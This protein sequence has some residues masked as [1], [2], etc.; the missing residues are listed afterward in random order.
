M[1]KFLFLFM[2][3][4]YQPKEGQNL[5]LEDGTNIWYDRMDGNQGSAPFVFVHGNAQNHT[6]AT[7][8]LAHL[9]ELGHPVVV[10]HLPGHGK[11]EA[12]N[13]GKY[14]MGRFSE[15]LGKV[16]A[17]SNIEKPILLAHSMGGM[18]AL[19]YATENP[20]KIR[21]L[22]LV[23]TADVDPVAVNKVVPLEKIV[24]EIV[25]GAYQA[26]K[27]G[28]SGKVFP[29]DKNPKLSEDEI[30]GIGLEHTIPQALDGNFQATTE[31]D[32]RDKIG[33]LKVP[34][35]II[36]GD[37]DPLMTAEMNQEMHRRLTDSRLVTVEGYG[38]NFL[39]QRPDLLVEKIKENYDFV[40]SKE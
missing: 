7:A 5:T 8:T 1:N 30:Q 10:Y 17:A 16:I 38:H 37:E 22:V 3:H 32:V 12:Y 18:I 28:L 26:F 15:T 40:T 4:I 29:Y 13:D 33:D 9:N 2:D 25:K 20:D 39:I 31:Y 6:T 36:R 19:Q 23:D 14:S 35:L 24:A 21:G 34:V 11:S 27:P